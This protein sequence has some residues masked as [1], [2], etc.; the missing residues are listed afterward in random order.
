MIDKKLSLRYAKALLGLCDDNEVNSDRVLDDLR[1]LDV[2]LMNNPEIFEYLSA[3]VIPYRNKEKV[4]SQ[5]CDDEFL[6]N[7]IKYIVLKGR[8]RLFHEIVETFEELSDEKKGRAKALVRSAVELDEL[9]IEKLK[10][11]L[12]KKLNKSVQF[13]FTTDSSLIA[14]IVVQVKDVVYDG[15]LRTYLSNLEHKLMRLSI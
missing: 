9:A 6:Y 10:E 1:E 12:K 4:I 11:Q 7:F 8:F 13:E 15:S 14:G 2:F 5:L 3:H